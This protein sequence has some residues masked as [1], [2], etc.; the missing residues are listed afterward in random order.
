MR[1]SVI[2]R[3]VAYDRSVGSSG[4]RTR[5]PNKQTPWSRNADDGVSVLRLPLDTHDPV[6]RARIGAMFSSAFSLRR[7]V[8]HD[9]R[10]RCRAYWAASHERQRDPAAVRDRL[11]LSR[12]ALEDAAY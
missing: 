11:G 5:G 2:V 4:K 9:A 3:G 1:S 12:K 10:S 6:Q 8:Q 7:A